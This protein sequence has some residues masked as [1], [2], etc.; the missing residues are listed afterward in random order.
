[1]KEWLY[2]NEQNKKW[3]GRHNNRKS[4]ESLGFTSKT[5]KSKDLDEMYDFLDRHHVPKLYQDWV[6]NLNGPINPKK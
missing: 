1:M 5:C 6:N 4:K 2:S 3:K